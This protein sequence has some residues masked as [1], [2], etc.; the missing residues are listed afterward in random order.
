MSTSRLSL[1]LGLLVLAGCGPVEEQPFP[2]E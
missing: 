1:T 2:E